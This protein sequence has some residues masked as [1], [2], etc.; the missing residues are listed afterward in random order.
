MD[1]WGRGMYVTPGVI[2]D[3]QAV[4]H[5]LVD[6]N[7]NIASYWAVLTMTIGS[8]AKRSSRRTAGQSVDSA[9]MEPDHHSAPAEARLFGQIHMGDV[10]RWYDKRTDKYLALDTGGDHRPLLVHRARR[11]CGYRLCQGTG[12]S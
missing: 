4:T 7:L 2:V 9:S 6:I 5:N 12:H 11:H 10:A 3:G 1:E 8:T